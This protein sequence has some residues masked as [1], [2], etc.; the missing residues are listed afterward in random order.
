V[1]L[2]ELFDAEGGLVARTA[3]RLLVDDVAS[4]AV[5]LSGP[6]VL[7]ANDSYVL[8]P[9]S[10][11]FQG[12]DVFFVES[13]E[14]TND[15]LATPELMPAPPVDESGYPAPF[16]MHVGPGDVDHLALDVAVPSQLEL[17]CS[18]GGV[19]SSVR[20][21]ELRLLAP[22]ASTVALGRETA[23]MPAVLT[24]AL[25]PGRHVLRLS[26]PRHEPGLSGTAVLCRVRLAE[27]GGR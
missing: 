13:A 21:L 24:Y 17:T 2:I 26:A 23:T 3:S 18:G 1:S 8:V 27:I 5:R 14:V 19:G 20:E 6:A 25:A 16:V 11:G 7:G 12:P 15:A 22:D 10:P 4:P 9:R